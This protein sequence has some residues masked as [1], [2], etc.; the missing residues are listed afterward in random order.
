MELEIKPGPLDYKL[1]MIKLSCSSVLGARKIAG[2]QSDRT[3]DRVLGVVTE[4]KARS[5]P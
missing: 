4:C 5:K 3:T 2:V 1:S